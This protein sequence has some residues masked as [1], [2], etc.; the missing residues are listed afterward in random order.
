MTK[1]GPLKIRLGRLLRAGLLFVLAPCFAAVPAHAASRP[2]VDQL[3]AFFDTIVFG[4][5]I[6]QNLANTMVTKWQGPI[7][8]GVKGN[9]KPRHIELLRK[10]LRAV[11]V[12]TGLTYEKPDGDAV[13]EN[14]SI[15]FVPAEKMASI[16]LGNVDPALLR[17]LAAPAGC[18]F[19]AFKNPPD[20]I[21]RSVIV[22]NNQRT[23]D[24]I[25]HCLLEELTQSLGLPNDSDDLRPSIFSDHDRLVAYSRNDE[26]LV[27][28]LYDD[29]LVPGTARSDAL[30]IARSIIEELDSKLPLR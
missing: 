28:T 23:M 12:A 8:V 18:Y 7:R 10:Q 9:P 21:I 13:P 27:R 29:R 17:K 11:G 14:V 4:S 30:K 19:L 25:E 26:I 16:K 1:R 2:S 15:V 24:A 3:L 22:V 20:R 5:E 6:D